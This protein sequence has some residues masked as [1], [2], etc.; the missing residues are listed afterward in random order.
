MACRWKTPSIAFDLRPLEMDTSLS[1]FLLDL[2]GSVIMYEFG[3]QVP[4][5]MRR[6]DK[7]LYAA[8]HA[9]RN[10]VVLEEGAVA[11]D[12]PSASSARIWSASS[13]SDCCSSS[14]PDPNGGSCSTL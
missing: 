10:R 2:E 6:A 14:L 1:R 4:T 5:L 3:P 8:K 9:G 12:R 13:C 11:W 7:A